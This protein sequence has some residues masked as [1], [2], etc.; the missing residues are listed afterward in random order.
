MKKQIIVLGSMFLVVVVLTVTR[1][2]I[3]NNLSTAGVDLS[4]LDQEIDAY[5]RKNALLQEKILHASA[6]T[7]L[8]ETAEK[9]GYEAMSKQIVLT[10]PLPIAYKR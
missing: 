9:R 6:Y 1:A 2:V 3:S 10:S 8:E 7:T 5:Q 4:R